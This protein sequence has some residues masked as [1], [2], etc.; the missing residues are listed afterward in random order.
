MLRIEAG[1]ELDDTVW[2]NDPVWV[3][4]DDEGIGCHGPCE[5]VRID[6][7]TDGMLIAH[8]SS[9]LSKADLSLWIS[10]AYGSHGTHV[11]GSGE[12]SGNIA[13]R[14]TREAHVWIEGGEGSDLPFHLN[15]QLLADGEYMTG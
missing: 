2:S 5:L 14:A 11:V 8:L 6:V 12:I 10:D 3:I 4:N 13:V 1:G 9:T 15:T 7:P